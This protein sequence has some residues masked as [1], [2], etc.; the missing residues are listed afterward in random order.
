[1]GFQFKDAFKCAGEVLPQNPIQEIEQLI[2]AAYQR[3]TGKILTRIELYSQPQEP[4]PA[5]ALAVLL[6]FARQRASGRPLQHI[7]GLQEFLGH[8]YQVSA[9][10]LVPRQETE[11]LVMAVI[12]SLGG[13]S[14]LP[15][16]GIEVGLGSG[17]I[18]V[19]LL[20]RFPG[21]TMTASDVSEP[22]LAVAAQNALGI[23]GGAWEQ[24]LKVLRLSDPL[25]VL[26][27]FFGSV[28]GGVDFV[29]SNPPY[30]ISTDAIDAEVVKNEPHEAL[31][32]PMGDPTYFY[33]KIALEAPSVLKTNGKSWVFLEVPHERGQEILRI[34]SKPKGWNARLL[35]DLT[36]R[37]RVLVARFE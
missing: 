37:D 10:V 18:S 28:G 23:L 33:S 4:F 29:I 11:G 21:L 1:M 13:E 15:L 22:A 26:A 3:E 36:G 14:G 27:P 16:S 35:P 25:A 5:T 19:E 6:D 7:T 8:E 20:S 32:A 2:T 24:R 9:A 12:T 31:F 17:V 30:L 34:F